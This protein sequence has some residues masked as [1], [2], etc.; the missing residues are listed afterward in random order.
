MKYFIGIDAGGSKTK[1]AIADEKSDIIY[2][3][4]GNAANILKEGTKSA[5]KLV[6]GLINKSLSDSGIFPEDIAGTV[7]GAAGAGRKSDAENFSA[8]LEKFL[9]GRFE[10]R[11]IS[12]AEAALEGAFGGKPGCILISGT[13]SIAYGKDKNGNIYRSG[14]FGRLIGDEGSG[15][16]IGRKGL[17]EFSRQLDGRRE[18]SL[19]YEVLKIKLNVKS[20]DDLISVV[21]AENFNIAS[22]AP[23]VI[24]TAPQGDKICL[25][26][27]DEETNELI[28]LGTSVFSKSQTG[29]KR[30]SL[31]GSIISTENYF[32]STFKQK[33]YKKFPGI[34]IIEPEFPP[35][36]GAVL[37]AI[38]LFKKRTEN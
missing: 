17:N 34:K 18:K 11:V 12:D 30:L 22:V 21:N 37:I 28:D 27:I 14:G 5:A 10:T 23:P 31:S 33:L 7:I 9:S 35:E 19:L 25:K 6:A 4:S 24:E 8:E 15:Y 29:E 32:S 38:K 16:S 26:I 1:I 3:A 20:P 36:T 13:G 2:S